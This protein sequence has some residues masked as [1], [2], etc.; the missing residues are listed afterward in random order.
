M[1]KISA[2]ISQNYRYFFYAML[3]LSFITGSGFWLLK[4]FAIQ[5]GDFGPES[6]F[7]QYPFLQFHGLSAFV[8]LMS[9]GAIFAS[10]VPKNWRY[11]RGKITGITIL[12]AVSFSIL[13]A[14]SLYYLVSEDWHTLLANSHAIMGLIL[15]V[16]LFIHI[17]LARKSKTKN[18]QLKAQRKQDKRNRYRQKKEAKKQLE[19]TPS[20]VTSIQTPSKQ[21]SHLGKGQVQS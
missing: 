4:T 8:M 6:H 15:P 11:Q 16:I 21:N 1:S 13:T 18:H 3:S 12:S 17:V 5:E 9:L 2:Q 19:V 10:H 20:L 7:L 14:Y